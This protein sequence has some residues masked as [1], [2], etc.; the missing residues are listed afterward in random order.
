ML[1]EGGFASPAPLF[2]LFALSPQ[3]LVAF[4]MATLALAAVHN[5]DA[6]S[7]GTWGVSSFVGVF[8]GVVGHGPSYEWDFPEWAKMVQQSVGSVC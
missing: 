2:P 1:W 3:P 7:G 6:F 5:W 4:K 8:G